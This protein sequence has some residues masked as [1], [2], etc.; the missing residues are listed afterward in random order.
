MGKRKGPSEGLNVKREVEKQELL[1]QSEGCIEKGEGS[2][3]RGERV[4]A[5][6]RQKGKWENNLVTER[7]GTCLS[8]AKLRST[9]SV[10]P[11]SV[12]SRVRPR[13]RHL[14]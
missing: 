5:Q 1:L 14:L 3:L 2:G 11:R 13:Y 4:Y 8:S 12:L 7:E 9:D 10:N 6:K